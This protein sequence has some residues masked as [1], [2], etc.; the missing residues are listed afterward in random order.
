MA[1][2]GQRRAPGFDRRLAL[3][4]WMMGRIGADSFESLAKNINNPR[5][6]GLNNDGHT[7]FYVQLQ[8]IYGTR[9]RLPGNSSLGDYDHNIIGHWRRI[10]ERRN[11]DGDALQLK[12]FQYLALLFAE[13]Y[14][15]FHYVV[16]RRDL[17]LQ[18]NRFLSGNARMALPEFSEGDLN[19]AAFWM[20]TGSGKTLL[21]HINILQYLHYAREIAGEAPDRIILLTPNEGLSRQHLQEL[22][23]S[24]LPARMF[25]AGQQP[26]LGL[27]VDVLDI[28]KLHD[29]EVF[30]RGGKTVPAAAFEGSNLVLVDEGHRGTSGNG[31]S[32]AWMRR[33]NQLCADGFSFEYSATFGQAVGASNNRQL[34]EIYAKCILFNYSYRYFHGDGYGKDY[35]ILNLP[36]N[37]EDSEAYRHYMVACLL[38]FYQQ[39]RIYQDNRDGLRPFRLALPLLVFVGGSVNVVRIRAGR[40]VSDVLEVLLV[41]ANFVRQ[42]GQSVDTIRRLLQG[43]TSLLDDRGQPLFQD[44][45][46]YLKDSGMSPRAIHKDML[47]LLFHA[48]DAA[49]MH[50]DHLKGADGEIGLRMGEGGAYFGVINVGDAA[51]FCKLC[52][53]REYG[54]VVGDKEIARPLFPRID[55]PESPIRILMGSR[56]FSEGW[57]SWRVSTMGL[58]NIGRSEG[59]QIIQL[60]GRG[61]RLQG[62]KFSLMR[63]RAFVRHPGYNPDVPMPPHIGELETLDIFGVRANYMEQFKGYLQR[64]GMEEDRDPL[65]MTLPVVA[66]LGAGQI[67]R[68]KILRPKAGRR[69]CEDVAECRLTGGLPEGLFLPPVELDLLPKVQVEY[70]PDVVREDGDDEYAMAVQTK[71]LSC[72][73]LD[74]LDFAGMHSELREFCSERG[75]NNFYFVRD[76]LR[77]LLTPADDNSGCAWYR[78]SIPPEELGLQSA[79]RVQRW[80]HIATTLLK[81][82]MERVY[83]CRQAEYERRHL[84]YRPLTADDPNFVRQYEFEV[85]RSR[86][87]I[88]KDLERIRGEIRAGNLKNVELRQKLDGF[89]TDG[90]ANAAAPQH[91]YTPLLYVT[92]T[93]AVSIKPVVLDTRQEL[94]FVIDLKSYCEGAPEHLSGKEVYLLRNQSRGR[95]V[96]FFEAGNFYPDFILWVLDAGRQ[97]IGFIDPKGLQHLRAGDPKLEFHKTIKDLQSQLGDPYVTLDSFI[98]SGTGMAD[99][100]LLPTGG[101]DKRQAY[102]DRHILFQEHSSHIA[103]MLAKMLP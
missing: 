45:F 1:N 62:N 70:G 54:L 84:E 61:V 20:A 22:S 97:H 3:Y 87:T 93:R 13:I 65:M 5:Y 56:K 80:Q 66:R 58:M 95:G 47:E 30:R 6:E 94:A 4:R 31:V 51:K 59:P 98:L 49:A 78:L 2:G 19:K 10:T 32:G 17:A 72:G 75:W 90:L 39:L 12:Y 41:L 83:R 26:E 77:Q 25:S 33:R 11:H 27:S 14:L 57:S 67:K 53:E 15:D 21:M 46:A 38:R 79:S 55:E 18:L 102:A 74:F 86:E 48:H 73:H 60:F 16:G 92:N 35:R 71:W 40:A 68:L 63:S 89:G 34:Q 69:F 29:D 96:G 7:H 23:L 64:E 36:E 81:K 42:G 28:H 100:D 37:H 43:G 9:M 8:T 52:K 44:S 85:Q 101:Q 88:I 76:E 24:G 50:L 103:D 82:Y 91:L 99:A